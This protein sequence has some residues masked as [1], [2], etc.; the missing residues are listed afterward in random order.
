MISF[1]SALLRPLVGS[2]LSLPM[3]LFL[4]PL[5]PA[6]LFLILPLS[7]TLFHALVPLLPPLRDIRMLDI[8]ATKLASAVIFTKSE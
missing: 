1:L 7:L 6:L 8:E 4:V 5:R 3:P 2:E